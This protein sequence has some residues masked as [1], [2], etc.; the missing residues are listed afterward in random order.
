MDEYVWL[1]LLFGFW[2]FEIV[3][4]ALKDRRGSDADSDPL[5]ASL[6]D[7]RVAKRQLSREV[8]ESARR[9]EDALKRWEERREAA[10]ADAPPPD[11]WRRPVRV[12]RQSAL[13]AIAGM[14]V[15]LPLEQEG[16]TVVQEEAVAPPKPV[17]PR[18]TPVPE[19][20]RAKHRRAS[21]IAEAEPIVPPTV[22]RDQPG[23][24]RKL[25]RLSDLQRAVVMSEILG[26]P[27]SL[28][29]PRDGSA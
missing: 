17:Q 25:A 9:A 23:G 24:L 13:E 4:K 27:V 10:T 1:L 14:L 26:P 16:L 3:G 7:P 12:R 28:A 22:R 2:I 29:P 20:R 5:D 6:K 19:K 11:E 8:T 15:D 18:P 21:E